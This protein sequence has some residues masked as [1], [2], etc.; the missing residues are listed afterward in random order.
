[1]AKTMLSWSPIPYKDLHV[2]FT[3]WNKMGLITG[4]MVY[5]TCQLHNS[6]WRVLIVT[7]GK[8]II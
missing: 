1:M 2:M 8:Q 5:I 4:S 6:R 3:F 7:V